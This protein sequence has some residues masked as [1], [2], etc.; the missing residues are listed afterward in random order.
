[1]PNGENYTVDEHF[2][3]RMYLKEFAEVRG[4]GHKEKALIW[5]FNVKTLEQM[6]LAHPIGQI[7]GANRPRCGA[8]V[9]FY[10]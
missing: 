10:D 9:H 4:S 6:H 3:S 2:I 5:Q 1:M 8:S 7:C